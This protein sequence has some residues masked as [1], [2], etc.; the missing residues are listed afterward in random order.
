MVYIRDDFLFELCGSTKDKF[1]VL[2]K[3]NPQKCKE[4][5]IENDECYTIFKSLMKKLNE[6]AHPFLYTSSAFTLAEDDLE[7]KELQLIGF[8]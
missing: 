4:W 1:E 5:K 3:D 8:L 6:H 2:V 7:A